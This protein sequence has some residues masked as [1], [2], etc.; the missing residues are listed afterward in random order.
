MWF[1]HETPQP[2]SEGASFCRSQRGYLVETAQVIAIVP[3]TLGIP[4]VRFNLQIASHSSV[5]VEQRT[6]SL[7][8][9]ASA[10]RSP[11]YP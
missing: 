3:D 2:I 5:T 8:S 11:V 1:H 4:H 7:D 6:L 10:Y 9:F